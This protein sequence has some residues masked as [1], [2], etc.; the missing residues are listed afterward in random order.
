MLVSGVPL[1]FLKGIPDSKVTPMALYVPSQ[2][3][4]LLFATSY[5]QKD[6]HI[7]NK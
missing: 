6:L 1:C 4:T 7:Q 2:G 5:M 3:Q